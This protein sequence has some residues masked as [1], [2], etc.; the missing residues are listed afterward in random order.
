MKR[1]LSRQQLSRLRALQQKEERY[2]QDAF[3]LEGIKL[4]QEALFCRFP[5]KAV[6]TTPDLPAQVSQAILDAAQEQNI[7]T[8]PITVSEIAQITGIKNPEGALAVGR[9]SQCLSAPDT[10]ELPALY[11]WGVNDPGNLGSVMRTAAWFGVDHICLSPQTVD[12]FNVKVIRGSMGAIFN[13]KLKTGI[14]SQQLLRFCAAAKVPV[15]AADMAGTSPIPPTSERW[16]LVL[17]S[18]SHGLPQEIITGATQV[19]GIPRIGSGESLNL[20]VAAGILLY[21]LRKR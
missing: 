7:A 1:L 9:L 4:V 15:L 21:T 11:L 8:Y 20:A 6:Y 18:E 13:I 12:P 5:L 19:V 2:N 3:L 16:I 17:G 14:T 10:Y